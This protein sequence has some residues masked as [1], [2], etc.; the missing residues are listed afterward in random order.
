MSRLPPISEESLN[1]SQKKVL[2]AI[3]DGPRGEIPLTGPFAAWVKAG[4]LGDNIQKLGASLRYET[5]LDEIVKE[6]VICCVG[7]H[8]KAKCELS[9]HSKLEINAGLSEKIIQNLREGAEPEFN[10]SRLD[11]AYRITNQLL[12]SHSV[13]DKA[14]TEGINEFGE[15]GMIELVSLVGYYCLVSLTLNI[16]EVPLDNG[17]EDPFPNKK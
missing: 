7:Y 6:M 3:Q 2:K 5:E 14:Y 17:M 11:L 4:K 1:E 15:Q 9:Y 8:Y 10:D 13:D 12:Q 16:F